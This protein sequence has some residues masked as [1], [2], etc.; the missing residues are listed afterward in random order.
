VTTDVGFAKER[1]PV[2]KYLDLSLV[3]EAAS[4]LN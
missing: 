4:R 1:V 2:D 3:K